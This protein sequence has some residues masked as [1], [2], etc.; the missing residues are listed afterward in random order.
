MDRASGM[1]GWCPI[2]K[3]IGRSPRWDDSSNTAQ[4]DS[5]YRL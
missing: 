4:H 5:E 3:L 2:Y 1:L